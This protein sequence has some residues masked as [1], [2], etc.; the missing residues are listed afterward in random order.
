[1][2]YRESS[3]SKAR[4]QAVR[5]EILRS[6]ASLVAEGGFRNAGM[7]QVAERAGV[8]T[9]TIYRYFKSRGVL[10]SEVFRIATEREVRQVK[11]ALAEE[12]TA[13]DRLESAL[14]VFAARALRGR[15]MAWALLAEPVDPQVDAERLFY[16]RA[17]A[18]LFEQALRQGI[19]EDEFPGQDA[20][21]SSAAVV[22]AM[23]EAL[24]GPLSPGSLDQPVEAID[25]DKLI[26]AI[27]RFCVN[28]VS[29]NGG[30]AYERASGTAALR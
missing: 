28:A 20:K 29:H 23:A 26:T 1:M 17:Y 11:A 9:G 14:R 13:Q 24:V 3:R 15:I 16:R 19:A 2:A 18:G 21:L 5:S 6:A 25:Q 8:A 22:G 10:F 27:V 4:K 12:G 7:A 30:E